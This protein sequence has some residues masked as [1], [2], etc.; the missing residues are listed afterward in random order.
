MRLAIL[1]AVLAPLA[2]AQ[3]KPD[4]DSTRAG[5]RAESEVVRPDTLDAVGTLRAEGALL[6]ARAEGQR[7]EA[8]RVRTRAD[9]L[10]AGADRLLADAAALDAEADRLAGELA[11]PEPAPARVGALTSSTRRLRLGDEAVAVRVWTATVLGGGPSIPVYALNLHDDEQTSVD[12][13]LDVVRQRGGRVVEL[14]HSGERNVTFR[15]GGRTYVADP[16]RMFTPAGRRRTLESLSTAT[17]AAER[18]LA[19][20]ADAVLALY[21]ADRPGV[22]VTLHN[23]TD[24]NYSAASYQRGGQYASDAAAVTVHRRSDPDDFFFVTDADLYRRLVAAGF[25][26]VLQDN[27]AAT[28]DGSL[29]VWAARQGVPYVNV[30]AQHGHRARQAEMVGA[31]YDVVAGE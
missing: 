7:A 19:A 11:E 23:N 13:A 17:P 2:A 8:A 26:A 22:V 16:N 6:R 10:A 18:A 25:N 31:L 5:G 24:A 9:S 27:R 20:F 28:D 12:A 4:A 1:L 3:D 30:E 21:T 15:V 29:S 14:Q